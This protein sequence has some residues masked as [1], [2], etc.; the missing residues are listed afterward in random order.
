MKTLFFE[1]S[2]VLF[3][4]YSTIYTSRPFLIISIDT[5]SQVDYIVEYIVIEADYHKQ[6]NIV[7]SEVMKFP[8]LI[9]ED[10]DSI[11]E[12]ILGISKSLY[13]NHVTSNKKFKSEFVVNIEMKFKIASHS[14]LHIL[15]WNKEGSLKT[16]KEVTNND[17]LKNRIS[18]YQSITRGNN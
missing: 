6:L 10:D 5:K 7:S 12:V 17:E 3:A 13:I 18:I 8:K 16:L 15:E 4:S 2:F 9:F 1:G 11:I 14:I